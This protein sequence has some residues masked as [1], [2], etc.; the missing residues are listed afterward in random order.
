M[1]EYYSDGRPKVVGKTLA[2]LKTAARMKKGGRAYPR[3]IIKGA[4]SKALKHVPDWAGDVGR[5]H[6][7]GQKHISERGYKEDFR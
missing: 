5:A 3:I 1:V 6:A 2:Q 4:K 7:R